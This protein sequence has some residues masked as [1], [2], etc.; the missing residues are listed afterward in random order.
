MYFTSKNVVVPFFYSE[1]PES[2]ISTGRHWWG[3]DPDRNILDYFKI[4]NNKGELIESEEVDS[5]VKFYIGLK[6]DH[7]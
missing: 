7:D 4:L 5:L 2:H 6:A 1:V 3:H